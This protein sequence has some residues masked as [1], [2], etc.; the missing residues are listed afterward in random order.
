MVEVVPRPHRP[1]PPTAFSKPWL[2]RGVWPR[3]PFQE[4]GRE[5]VTAGAPSPARIVDAE[6]GRRTQTAPPQRRCSVGERDPRSTMVGGHPGHLPGRDPGTEAGRRGGSGNGGTSPRI[7]TGGLAGG[8]EPSG[9]SPPG[10]R[11][12]TADPGRSGCVILGAP[13]V[14]TQVLFG[15][16]AGGSHQP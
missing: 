16:V 8:G 11:R 15:P 12:R 10:S 3:Q 2:P 1:R 5:G 4:S 14:R 7:G 6:P 9:R 13:P